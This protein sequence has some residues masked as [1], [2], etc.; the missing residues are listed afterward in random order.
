MTGNLVNDVFCNLDKALDIVNRIE[1][2]EPMLPNEN[3]LP[4]HPPSL[5]G[6]TLS[7]LCR[8]SG[9]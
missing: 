3:S 1:E 5:F 2:M 4:R 7:E 6:K 8:T 9:I